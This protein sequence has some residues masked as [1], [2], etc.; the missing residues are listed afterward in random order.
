LKLVI[1][2]YLIVTGHFAVSCKNTHDGALWH[3]WQINVTPFWS[4]WESL[5]SPPAK[6]QEADP[7]TVGTNQDDRLE[8]FVVGQDSAV[9]HIWQTQ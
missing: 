4:K 2:A 8:V 9:W 1:C 7:L 5:G 6:I 3:A